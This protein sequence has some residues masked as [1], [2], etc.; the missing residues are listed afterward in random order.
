MRGK[1]DPCGYLVG[2][3]PQINEASV[4][5]F[6]DTQVDAILSITSEGKKEQRG[7]FCKS[8]L[9]V[10]CEYLFPGQGFSASFSNLYESLYIIIDI[11]IQIFEIVMSFNFIYVT[12][13]LR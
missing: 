7:C 6:L 2:K 12:C 8:F 11:K 4:A 5:G 13:L 9:P 1:V 3:I 10:F